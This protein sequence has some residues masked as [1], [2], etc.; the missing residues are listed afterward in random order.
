MRPLQFGVTE[1]DPARAFPGF[2][3]FSPSSSTASYLIDMRGEIRKQWDLPGP[4]GNYGQL[5]PNGNL[6]VTLKTAEG[7]NFNPAG[8]RI[9]ELD[10]D[11]EIV[12]DH[13][14]HYQHHDFN[15][16]PNGNT[17]YLAWEL[18]PTDEAL[19]QVVGGVPGSEHED[20]GVYYDVLRE[21]NQAGELV[22]EWRMA[23]HFP[24]EKYPL[25]VNRPREE[26]AHANACF[27]QADGNIIIS[28]RDLDLIA[29]L[30][31]KT[32]KFL[33]EI[34]DRTFGGQH[35][36]RQLDNGNITLFANGSE[37]VDPEFSRVLEINPANGDIVWSYRGTPVATFYSARIS[38]AQRLANGNTFICE[39]LHGRL[40]EVTPDGDI[41]WEFISPHL[42]VRGGQVTRQIFRSLR[43]APGSPEIGERLKLAV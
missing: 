14:D 43:Y 1:Y 19:K 20:G 13:I 17:V 29:L 30:D 4:V 7:P 28:W 42:N 34:E 18:I 3:L 31:R 36:P 40:F 21:V 11:G 38:G 27:V 10:W 23:E 32:G 35:D 9:L 12:W 22:W 41:V 16:L 33:W 8:G 5:L 25:R 6:L 39:G 26:F 24:F 15:R 2:T 37:Q